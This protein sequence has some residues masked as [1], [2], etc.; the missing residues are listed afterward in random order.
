[1]REG[2]SI[3]AELEISPP[4]VSENIAVP[5]KIAGETDA[6][7]LYVDRVSETPLTLSGDPSSARERI[8]VIRS[9]ISADAGSVT[10]VFDSRQDD[11]GVRESIAIAIDAD[12]L[13]ENYDIGASHTWTV[14]INDKEARSLSFLHRRMEVDEGNS[15]STQLQLSG[16][17]LA[18]GEA[19]A[20]PLLIDGDPDAYGVRAIAPSGARYENGTVHFGN[21]DFVALQVRARQDFDNDD[22]TVRFAIDASRLPPGYY[23]GSVGTFEMFVRDNRKR[24]VSF[25]V[26]SATSDQIDILGGVNLSPRIGESVDVLVQSSTEEYIDTCT[27]WFSNYYFDEPVCSFSG[28]EPTPGRGVVPDD[29][30]RGGADG[31][32]VSVSVARINDWTIRFRFTARKT[33]LYSVW[34]DE[35]QYEG[36]IIGGISRVNIRP[37]Q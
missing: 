23:V 8:A 28:G 22:D 30:P 17:P 33:G 21:D 19:L 9:D 37:R 13:P 12:S 2:D 20:V 11:D 35:V 24:N 32:N 15:I 3:S 6:Y 4:L 7:H 10:L 14:G 34:L 27:K 29:Y 1:M 31:D 36:A 18:P 26:P 16:P 25:V 5:L